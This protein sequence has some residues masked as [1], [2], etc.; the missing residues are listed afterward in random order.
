VG[1]FGVWIRS[2]AI[3]TVGRYYSRDIALLGEQTIVETGWYRYVRHP[4]YLGTFLTYVGFAVSISSL[5]AVG[6]NVF[7]FFA[8]YSHRIKVEERALIEAFGD[9]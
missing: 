3:T 1:L 9:Q 2:S 4:G 8:A 5:L 6:I 7:L